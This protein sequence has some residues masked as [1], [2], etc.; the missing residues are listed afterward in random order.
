[1]R[2]LNP[3]NDKPNFLFLRNGVKVRKISLTQLGLGGIAYIFSTIQLKR[4]T[5]AFYQKLC[6]GID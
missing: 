4:T 3:I 1:M 6:L 2:F 5:T